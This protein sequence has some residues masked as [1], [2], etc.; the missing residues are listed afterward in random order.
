M[1]ATWG[2]GMYSKV[3]VSK[4]WCQMTA[5]FT[6]SVF[7]GSRLNHHSICFSALWTRHSVYMITRASFSSHTKAISMKPCKLMPNL[8]RTKRPGKTWFCL[9]VRMD[10]CMG[11]ISIPRGCKLG[12]RLF[13]IIKRFN[14]S[15][16]TLNNLVTWTKTANHNK[17]TGWRLETRVIKITKMTKIKEALI[18]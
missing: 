2:C 8:L 6:Q 10:T 17:T 1:T 15:N 12:Y 14:N 11:G 4:P 9:V 7:V 18:P 5:A 3:N 16:K 13:G